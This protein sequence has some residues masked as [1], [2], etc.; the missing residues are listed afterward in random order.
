M[1]I[2]RVVARWSFPAVLGLGLLGQGAFIGHAAGKAPQSELEVAD[3]FGRLRQARATVPADDWL[4]TGEALRRLQTLDGAVYSRRYGVLALVGKPADLRGP[5]HL[6]DLMVALRAAYFSLQPMSMTIDPD[7]HN[8]YGSQM[9]VRFMGGCQN[10]AFGWVMFECDRQLKCLTNG[11]DNV[12]RAA[13]KVDVPDFQNILDLTLRLGRTSVEEW[14]RFWLT[15]DV[16]GGPSWYDNPRFFNGT[17]PLL[18]ESNDQTAISF[19]HCRLYLRTEV[20]RAQ[21][22]QLVSDVGRRSTAAETFADHFNRHF[23][24]FAAR[25]PELSRL[26]GLARLVVVAEWISKAR[27]PVDF[28]RIRSYQQQLPVQTPTTTPANTSSRQIET[29]QV[30]AFGGV[31]FQSRGFYA[32]DAAGT[33]AQLSRDVDRALAAHPHEAGWIDTQ[34]REPRWVAVLPTMRA[35]TRLPARSQMRGVAFRRAASKDDLLLLPPAQLVRKEYVARE[36]VSLSRIDEYRQ[37]PKTGPPPERPVG[38]ASGRKLGESQRLSRVPVEPMPLA[39]P[40]KAG[41]GILTTGPPAPG[42]PGSPP[43]PRLPLGP[44]VSSQLQPPGKGGGGLNSAAGG[45]T[46]AGTS[47]PR[48]SVAAPATYPPLSAQASNGSRGGAGPSAS[49]HFSDTVGGSSHDLRHDARPDIIRPEPVPLTSQISPSHSPRG[50]P[51]SPV[52]TASNVAAFCERIEVV[53]SEHVPL[54]H[55]SATA[56]WGC[57]LFTSSGKHWT[58]DVPRLIEYASPRHTRQASVVGVPNTTINVADQLLL[59]SETGRIFVQ[60]GQPR[61]DQDRA[62]YYYPPQ[63]PAPEKLK[64]YYPQSRTLEFTDGMQINLNAAGEPSTMRMPDGTKVE[65]VYSLTL[66]DPNGWPFPVACRVTSMS[67]RADSHEFR[68]VADGAAGSTPK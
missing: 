20:M 47:T 2:R 53:R 18:W 29:R 61:I 37:P 52:V 56:V 7:P 16:K 13:L 62:V 15:T 65:L 26:Q 23:D 8:I 63:E 57:P 22:G 24:E 42:R 28:E 21:A 64:G 59:L 4:Q 48:Q 27:L 46:S 67:G 5:F 58:F 55:A 35:E 11:Q 66:R 31:D 50:P 45:S 25:S 38:L 51:R 39:G 34:G 43:P 19:K 3:I 40:S 33:A 60:F 68:L 44:T 17:Q 6:D 10:T 1:N 54:V 9:A 36:L 41:G 12:T 32:A 30:R 49:T 14:D